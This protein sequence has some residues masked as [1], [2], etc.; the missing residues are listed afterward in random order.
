[1]HR[2]F[3]E[4]REKFAHSIYLVQP[5]NN[6]DYII[7]TDASV[8][9]I[10]AVLM[11]RDKEGR[12]N[13]VSTASRVLTPAEQKYTTCEFELLAIVYAL[14]KFRIYIHGH[15]VTLNTDHKSLTFLKKCVV[16]STRVACWMLEI[17]QWDLEIRHIK[18]IDNALADVLSRNPPIYQ[19]HNATNSRQRD[20]IMVHAINLNIDSTVKGELKTL[21][22]VQN[23]DPRLLAI[24]QEL[25]THPTTRTK[26][27]MNNDILYCKGDKE[28]KNW[29]AM[30][31]ECLE[32]KIM[33]FVHTSLGHLGSDKCNAEIK[34]TFH[35]RGLSRKLRKF[36][37]T[38]DLCQ[39]TKHMNRAYDV[40]E[41]HHLPHLPGELC[42]V[43]LY[44]NL[45]TSRSNV[46]YIF[47]CYDVFSKYVKLYPIKSATTNACINRLLNHYF[48]N[49]IKPKVVL[50]DNGSQF[51]SPVWTKKLKEHDVR[52]RF[53]L[54]GTHR[55]TTV[56]EL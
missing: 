12:S 48:I 53:C 28:G 29:K 9:A 21:A 20:Q 25:T 37:A 10:G 14:R 36:I 38:C 31:P 33:L 46:K 44:G 45:P 1:M 8:K 34:D 32:R 43:D 40:A 41:R 15:K 11:Q 27:V 4:L 55:A 26:Y 13:I 54:L 24:K 49:V 19:S 18:G 50:S 52:T 42:A 3:E 22:T 17:E 39:R 47:V 7:N 30:L 35:F 6:Q 51:R 16:S 56:K 23:T 2:T 5:D